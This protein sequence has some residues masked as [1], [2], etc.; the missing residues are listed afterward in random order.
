MQTRTKSA[1]LLLAVLAIGILIGILVSGA[2][3]NR[4]MRSLA[5]MRTGPGFAEMV[6]RAVQP[7]SEEQ[8][9]EIRAVLDGAAPRFAEMFE[10]NRREM[11]E[12]ADS[13]MVELEAVLDD[14][15]VERLRRMH[16]RMRQGPPEGRRG[17]PGDR[18]QGRPPPRGGPPPD[19]PPP[20]Q[21]LDGP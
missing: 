6:E 9:A 18:R 3:Q 1:F 17:R 12:L 13:V 21:P 8:R 7:R 20:E 15:Q 16:L 10:R 4:R 2:M 11:G 19:G 5:L 14:D